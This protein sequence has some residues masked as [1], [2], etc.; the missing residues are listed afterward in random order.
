MFRVRI[1][2]FIN[3]IRPLNGR[4]Q[5]LLG[6]ETFLVVTAFAGM[7]LAISQSGNTVKASIVPGQLDFGSVRPGQSLTAKVEFTA[8]TDLIV[9]G[10]L[11]SCKC[12][13]AKIE[14]HDVRAGETT[15]IHIVIEVP[16]VSKGLVE[17][18]IPVLFHEPTETGFT[19]LRSIP[20]S[21]KYHVR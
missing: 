13:T 2:Q 14:K 10:A 9:Q 16:K 5:M 15:Y 17:D 21:M 11:P 6:F 18:R 3:A 1:N 8:N 7:L 20:I 4:K 19:E 12:T